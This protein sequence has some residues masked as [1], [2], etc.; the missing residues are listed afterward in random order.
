MKLAGSRRND[1]VSRSVFGFPTS[2]PTPVR[3]RGG[4]PHAWSDDA[5]AAQRRSA[6]SPFAVAHLAEALTALLV[7]GNARDQI[8]RHATERCSQHDKF[9]LTLKAEWGKRVRVSTGRYGL[10]VRCDRGQQGTHRE[11]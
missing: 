3:I 8:S 9:G 7:L 1:G 5:Q 6:R 10:R 2:E 11:S 4:M